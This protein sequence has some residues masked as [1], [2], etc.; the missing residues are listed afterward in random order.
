MGSADGVDSDDDEMAEARRGTGV[1]VGSA[2][3]NMT[4]LEEAHAHDPVVE[5]DEGDRR[6]MAVI[7]SLI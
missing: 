3:N 2:S 1:L 7:Q 5:V 6:D 4:E